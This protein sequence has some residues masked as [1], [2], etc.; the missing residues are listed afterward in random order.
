MYR[1]LTFPQLYSYRDTTF[2]EGEQV[3]KR[4]EAGLGGAFLL[5]LF[6]GCTALP[7][8]PDSPPGSQAAS[9]V[10]GEQQDRHVRS[11]EREQAD[12]GSRIPGYGGHYLDSNGREPNRTYHTGEQGV[13]LAGCGPHLQCRLRKGDP[14]IWRPPIVGH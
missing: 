4:H 13:F 7:S 10:S 2:K 3:R 14:A 8:D 1:I 5:C 6:G 11:E 9:S 12:L